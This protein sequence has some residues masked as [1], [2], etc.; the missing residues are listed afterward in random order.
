MNRKK[1]KKKQSIRLNPVVRADGTVWQCP[2][3]RREYYVTRKRSRRGR[4]KQP[5]VRWFGCKCGYEFEARM[6]R[7]EFRYTRLVIGEVVK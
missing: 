3:C 6:E 4:R 1:R 7:K 5:D 2:K